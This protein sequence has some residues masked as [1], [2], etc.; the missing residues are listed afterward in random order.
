[1]TLVVDA[2]TTLAAVL[3]DE[4]SA[5]ARAAFAASGGML[6][7]PALWAYEV[8]NGLALAIRRKRIDPSQLDAILDI[9]RSLA[10]TI[11]HPHGLGREIRI[12]QVHGLSAYDAAYLAA[13]I[14]TGAKLAT[15]DRHLR[16]VSESIGVAVFSAA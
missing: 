4:H 5:Y 9:L 16:E 3:P 15:Y 7:V 12:A 10:P 1:M 14:N 2:S 11:E 6:V 8:Q 13:A